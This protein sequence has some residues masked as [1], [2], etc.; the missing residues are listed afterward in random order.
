MT[1]LFTFSLHLVASVL[2]ILF[3]VL[4]PRFQISVRRG[5]MWST[6]IIA[7]LL[8]VLSFGISLDLADHPLM[9][10]SFCLMP[11]GIVGLLIAAIYRFTTTTP[12]FTVNR[13]VLTIAPLGLLLLVSSA[14]GY[15]A[16]GAACNGIHRRQMEPVRQALLAYQQDSARFPI[17][18]QA[19]VPFYLEEKPPLL[20][21]GNNDHYRLATCEGLVVLEMD[22]FYGLE[23]HRLLLV[24]GDWETSR[25]KLRS[26]QPME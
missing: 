12:D 24:S 11:M 4:L 19:L 2:I 9:F 22:D 13:W 14:I 26:C 6:F 18:L 25:D 5:V 23:T 10:T 1:T 17:G 3:M 8:I 21:F 20:C 16:P 15:F 7:L